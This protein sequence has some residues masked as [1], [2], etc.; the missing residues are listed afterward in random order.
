MEKLIQV[1]GLKP[2]DFD[3]LIEN[4][5]DLEFLGET[6]SYEEVQ[7]LIKDLRNK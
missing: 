7:D 4:Q 5:I 3:I 1:Y 6:L 2:E